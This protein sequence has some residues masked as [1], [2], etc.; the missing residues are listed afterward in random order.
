MVSFT[1]GAIEMSTQSD[2]D[3]VLDEIVEKELERG[4]YNGLLEDLEGIFQQAVDSCFHQSQNVF[5][6]NMN[7]RALV[8]LL[9]QFTLD[10][11]HHLPKS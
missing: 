11:N 9:A 3:L 7:M 4:D 5:D 2:S 10:R 8:G 6:V 1:N